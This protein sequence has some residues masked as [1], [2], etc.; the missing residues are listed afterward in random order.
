MAGALPKALKKLGHDIR[1]ILPRY[2]MVGIKK[3]GLKKVMD[4]IPVRVGNRVEIAKVYESK[5]PGTEVIVYFI[6]HEKYFGSRDGLYQDKGVDYADNCERFSFFC[7]AVME[8]L[9][10]KEDFVPEIIHSN[11]WQTALI[12]A[13]IK[14][15]YKWDKAATVYSIHNMA[16]QG[17]FEKHQIL[18]TG[19]SWEMFTHEKLE[20]YDKLALTKAGF[21]FADVINTVSP[22]YAKEIQTKE[23]G[24]GLEGLMQYRSKDIYGILNG[25]DYGIWNPKTDPSLVKNY[26]KD[27]LDLKY[28]NKLALQNRNGLPQD[29][30]IPLIGIVSRLA[31]Q[32]GFDILS[33]ALDDLMK[34]GVQ[35]IILGTGE[36][37]YHRLLEEKAN[38]YPQQISIALRFDAQLAEMIY[39]GSD[40]FLMPSHYEPC[41]LG[42]LIS[43]A[44][45][46]IPIVR[47]TGGLVDTVHDGVDGFVFEKPTSEDLVAA[48]KHALGHFG[49]TEW[50]EMMKRIME[51]DYSWD[52]SAKK[53][54]ELYKQAKSRKGC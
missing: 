7:R 21:V 31:Q 26:N 38:A 49:R 35:I 44:Y 24:C 19:F 43:F 10:K 11:D 30:D 9:L 23:F 3:L 34:L 48:V 2:K 41:G 39:G 15:M 5:I 17:L 27:T 40:M 28:E 22:T 6:D 45:G 33:E 53:Y 29:K 13:Y 37:E 52:A 54:E 51:Y 46:T 42:Q 32:K 14:E 16:Y 25:I 8:F 12:A 50:K 20:F 18:Q 1:I 36:P 47:K 4:S